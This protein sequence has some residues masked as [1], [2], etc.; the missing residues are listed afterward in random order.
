MRSAATGTRLAKAK[1]IDDLH[2]SPLGASLLLFEIRLTGKLQRKSSKTKLVGDIC[3]EECR[4]QGLA[5]YK[6]LE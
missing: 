4:S 6:I 5:V 3:K 2:P 1:S